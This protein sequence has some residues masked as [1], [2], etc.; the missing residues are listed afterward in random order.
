MSSASG[1]DNVV[2]AATKVGHV[3]GEEGKLVYRGYD[4]HQLAAKASFEE[5]CYLLW[6]GELPNRA[7]LATL[8]QQMRSQRALNES[9][10]AAIKGLPRSANPMDALRTGASAIGAGD[11]IEGKPTEAQAIRLAA[12]FREIVAQ[13]VRDARSDAL[14]KSTQ[15]KLY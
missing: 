10:V 14:D 4:I 6:N 9:A 13:F 5:V 15:I 7:Q 3:F 12:V 11:P 8:A 2:V 1:L